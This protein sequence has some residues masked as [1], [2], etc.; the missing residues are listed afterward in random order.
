MSFTQELKALATASDGMES[1]AEVSPHG[2]EV[3]DRAVVDEGAELTL[4]HRDAKPV[5]AER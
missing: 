2:R 3:H 4:E 1:R 5:A